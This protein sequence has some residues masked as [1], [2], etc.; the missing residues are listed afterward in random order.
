MINEPYYQD[1]QVTLYHGD[2][3][4]IT[5][6]LA[7]DVLVT[8]P[9]YGMSYQSGQRAEKFQA[10]AGDKDV[11]CRD[12]ALAVWGTERPAAVFGTW[13]V[14][15]PANVRQC[16]IW[17]KRGAGPGMGDLTTAFGTSHEEIYLI[18]H[19]AK[20]STRRGSV[21]TTESS[22]SVLTSR[23]GHPT[24]KPIGLME[25]IIAAAPEGVVADPFAG[26][27]STL[28]AA[29]N[30]GR[31]AIGVELEE[32]YCEIAAKRLDQMCLDFGGAS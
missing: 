25:T 4:E 10:I 18:G 19:W 30:L 7:A 27:G 24:P 26:S 17:D 14:A 22:P 28:V 1:D 2:C 11:Q 23:I 32:R 29:R 12:R 16:L 20:R 3:L 13:R 6:W 8:D 21:I 15:K 5:E 31:R 9:P